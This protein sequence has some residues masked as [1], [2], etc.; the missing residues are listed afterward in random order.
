MKDF[1]QY[2]NLNEAKK[3]Q[4][5]EFEDELKQ[6]LDYFFT[7]L[8]DRGVAES[9]LSTAGVKN[10]SSTDDKYIWTWD[11]SRKDGSKYNSYFRVYNY[12][13][14]IREYLEDSIINRIVDKIKK[15]PDLKV[16]HLELSKA[17]SSIRRG[18]SKPKSNYTEIEL[19]VYPLEQIIKTSIEQLDQILQKLIEPIS[20]GGFG[21]KKSTTLRNPLK[22]V[23]PSS[24]LD[25]RWF[26]I[27]TKSNLKLEEFEKILV[28]LESNYTP[29]ILKFREIFQFVLNQL[30]SLPK[31]ISE[32]SRL[33]T[34]RKALEEKYRR[35]SKFSRDYSSISGAVANFEYIVSSNSIV[36]ASSNLSID[37]RGISDKK[38]NFIQFSF[39]PSEEAKAVSVKPE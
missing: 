12:N 15:L 20:K 25:P 22:P 28:L 1:E 33:E 32:R 6:T 29:F 9:K 26:I 36:V 8:L 10:Q 19:I 31:D 30:K 39:K 38:I 13:I 16:F 21:F 5:Q 2:L 37:C 27:A 11:V 34:V 23:I 18:R 35:P 4:F 17:K 14:Y 24:R 3:N 7:E